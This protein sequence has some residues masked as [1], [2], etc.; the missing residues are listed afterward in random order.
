M[1]QT[2]KV[3]GVATTVE[4]GKSGEIVAVTYHRT[5][6]F[7]RDTDATVHL[8]TGGWKTAATKAR[9]NQ[10]MHESGLPWSVFQKKRK[11]YVCNRETG[12]TLLFDG[13]TITLP[14]EIQ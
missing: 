8:D 11:W 4:R 3:R 5:K 12:T 9:M 6:V 13:N 7:R 2:Q 1:P 10:A 14:M